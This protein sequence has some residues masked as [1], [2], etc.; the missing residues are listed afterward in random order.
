M[1][2]LECD[3]VSFRSSVPLGKVGEVEHRGRRK[4]WC[5]EMRHNSGIYGRRTCLLATRLL[6][7]NPDG[8][9]HAGNLILSLL[10]RPLPMARASAPR[11]VT[12]H[13]C[14]C[15]CRTKNVRTMNKH[16]KLHSQRLNIKTT[17]LASL[18]AVFHP[19]KRP[20]HGADGSHLPAMDANNNAEL[21]G[22]TDGSGVVPE[23]PTLEYD[24][25]ETDDGG[26]NSDGVSK[27][28]LVGSD[29][30]DEFESDG[31]GVAVQEDGAEKGRRVLDFELDAARSG[32]A[33]CNTKGLI[34]ID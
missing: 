12:E 27:G 1:V 9:S 7:R 30:E 15:G 26:D 3:S 29:S 6:R 23:G 25:H 33:L 14:V 13:H 34:E 5:G 22:Q 4:R 32:N 2:S 16:L 31:E 21:D 17:Q 8:V 24:D 20:L 11:G 10:S 19:K 28:M 18:T